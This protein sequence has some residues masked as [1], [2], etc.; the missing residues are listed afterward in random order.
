MV[1]VTLDSE[2]MCPWISF[3]KN[4][5]PPTSTLFLNSPTNFNGSPLHDRSPATIAYPAAYNSTGPS[6]ECLTQNFE[7]STP[8]DQLLNAIN[9]YDI[10]IDDEEVPQD[11]AHKTSHVFCCPA[12]TEIMGRPDMRYTNPAQEPSY[13]GSTHL[14]LVD[15]SDLATTC[16]RNT[17]IPPHDVLFESSIDTATNGVAFHSRTRRIPWLSSSNATYEQH[18]R[19]GYLEWNP[20]HVPAHT[21]HSADKP[22]SVVFCDPVPVPAFD[23]GQTCVSSDANQPRYPWPFPNETMISSH[24][25]MV[26]DGAHENCWTG[27]AD[28]LVPDSTVCTAPESMNL[29]K[30]PSNLPYQTWERSPIVP[31]NHTHC[32]SPVPPPPTSSFDSNLSTTS[33]VSD[34]SKNQDFTSMLHNFMCPATSSTNIEVESHHQPQMTKSDSSYLSDADQATPPPSKSFR[35]LLLVSWRQAG[36]SYKNIKRFGGLQEPESTLR[37]RFRR[38]TKLTDQRVRKP[39]WQKHDVCLSIVPDSRIDADFAML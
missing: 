11:P 24:Y 21:S 38:L 16:S 20:L 5:V 34:A 3:P 13:H 22:M 26:P 12:C 30:L 4:K 32:H 31:P 8:P 10:A 29:V 35:D 9:C 25:R 27:L 1:D 33:K 2:A 28:T 7:T 15:D 23:P 17:A 19:S 39:K 37:G 6:K 18:W 36:L 14:P